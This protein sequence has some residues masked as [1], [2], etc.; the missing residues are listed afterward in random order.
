MGNISQKDIELIESHLKDSDTPFEQKIRNEY[1]FL[2]NYKPNQ[3][4]EN[5][6]KEGQKIEISKGIINPI[7]VKKRLERFAKWF[8]MVFNSENEIF[9]EKKLSKCKSFP[10]DNIHKSILSPKNSN[11]TENNVKKIKTNHEESI[12]NYSLIT[13]SPNIFELA[14][15]RYYQINKLH[16]LQRVRKGPPDSLRWISWMIITNIPE[17]RNDLLYKKYLLMDVEQKSDNQIKKDLNRT[18]NENNIIELKRTK[19]E[20]EEKENNLYRVLRVMANIDKD[21][22]YCQ[23][24]NFI[25]GFLLEMND[26]NELETFYMLIS[27]FSKNFDTNFNIRGFYIDNFPLLS[28]YLY[29]F[30]HIL[31][32]ENPEFQKFIT[33]LEISHEAWIGKWIQTLYT[34]CFPPYLNY[35]VWDNILSTGLYFIIS[36]SISLINHISKD[37]MNLEDAFDFFEYIKKFFTISYGD[38]TPT[39]SILYKIKDN[40][41][42]IILE[43]VLE[44]AQKLHKSYCSKNLFL[45]LQD[46]YTLKNSI[47]SYAILYDID[48]FSNNNSG[49]LNY[50]ITKNGFSTSFSSYLKSNSIKEDEENANDECDEEK[51]NYNF[52][53]YNYVFETKKNLNK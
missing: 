19:S 6:K 1:N 26:Y 43:D 27:L 39:G 45:N 52:M 22:G 8:K 40:N 4:N 13:S 44:Q 37:L 35:R 36:F 2:K 9:I 34:I 17:Y 38:G 28:C 33:K 24:I 51:D 48:F 31:E 50:H 25:T 10:D 7:R 29:I 5:D 32:K 15:R 16:F 12:L 46:E 21:C 3:I 20:R 18:V 30:D 47:S 53:N 42:Y 14:L 49:N 41:K 23:G 11:K